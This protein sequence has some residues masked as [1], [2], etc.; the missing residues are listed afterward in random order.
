[1]RSSL[2][3][4]CALVLGA[5]LWPAAVAADQDVA[6]QAPLSVQYK[7]Q[8]V[9]K[10]EIFY[11]EAGPK[12][13][14][15][16][17]L[18][19]GYPSSSHMYRDLIPLLAAEYRVIAPDLPGFGSTKAPPRGEYAYSFANLA[20]AMEGFTEA[21][22]LDQYALYVFDY[23]APTGFRLA[24]KHPE[25]IT[26]IITQNG[27]AYEDGLLPAWGPV[28]TYWQDPTPE[29]RN[30]LR[31]LQTLE[32]TTWQYY[33]GV[34]DALHA[35]VG[36]DG[37]AHDQAILDRP[38]GA[39]IQLD[40]VGDYQSN[41]ALYPAWQ[42]YFRDHQPP[43]LAVWGEN[44]PFFGPEGAAAFKRDIPAAEIHLFDTGHFALETHAEEIG[45]L[46]LDFLGRH[47]R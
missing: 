10:L 43:L 1:M 17:L 38:G 46:M 28:R 14:Q 24:V 42:A 39:E 23:G 27:N 36:P 31:V 8:P 11:R 22:D 4:V 37:I 18:L 44:D 45:A 2:I 40:L 35:R 3:A 20:R 32:T 41:V 29:N 6:A 13:A 33:E 15:V 7:V 34:P 26:A 47:V 30:A 16:V 5:T 19:H 25:R 9:G 21:L 12:D